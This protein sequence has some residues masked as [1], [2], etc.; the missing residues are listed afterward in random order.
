MIPLFDENG[1]LPSGIHPATLDD[2]DTRFGQLSEIRRAQMQSIRWMVDLAVRAGVTRIVL[3]GSWVTDI[4]EPNDVD[5]VLL[6]ADSL[7][8]ADAE[9]ELLQGLPFLEILLVDHEEF[10][11]LV[12]VTF[13]TDRFGIAKGMVEVLL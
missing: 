1:V 8:D 13:A 2:V 7:L 10:S 5:C 9:Q 3:N 12:S 11:E 6:A 4:I